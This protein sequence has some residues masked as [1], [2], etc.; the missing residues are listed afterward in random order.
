[1]TKKNSKKEFDLNI[2]VFDFETDRDKIEAFLENRK[3]GFPE[4]VLESV[5]RII[6]EVRN[7][8]DDALYELT[9][10]FDGF[11]LDEN[12]IIISDDELEAAFK[13]ISNELVRSLEVA[14]E[15]IRS[16][17][18]R[19]LQKSVL[20]EDHLGCLLGQIV[21][22]VQRA[23]I[24]VPGGR[25]N[26]PSTALMNIIP[27]Q[28]AGVDEIYVCVP[29]DREGK[30]SQTTLAALYMLKP[31]KV[32]RVG[33]AQAIAALALGTRTIPKVDVIAGPGNIYVAAAKK[34][35]YG[36]VGIDMVAG[37]SEVVVV[38]DETANPAWVSRDL[39]AQA[40][41]D[42]YAS[43]YLITN[44]KKLIRDVLLK[45]KSLVPKSQRSEI[46][47]E[48]LNNNCAFF[49]VS[50]I[51]QGVNLANE[52]SPEHL[53]LETE[54]PLQILP[55]VK[56]CGAVF[57]GG[58]TAESFGDYILGPNH[59]LPT[60]S[61]ARFASPLSAN[62]FTKT[63]SVAYAPERA[64]IELYPYLKEIALSEGLYEH[65]RAAYERFKE[66]RKRQ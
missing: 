25:A 14:S 2:R 36:E 31:T 49:L 43:A 28:V 66:V 29:P 62:T 64:V 20:Y 3:K 5:S 9:L 45:L 59:T 46:I 32:F 16:F 60:Q 48:A 50:S 40:E 39:L 52:I 65:E 37:P 12:T 38:A 63:I 55:L 17:H 1:M 4:E 30:V 18:E 33:G 23:G 8:G 22:P 35:L 42:P 6:E 47:A 24:Y 61:T 34:M 58:T 15:R 54:K 57:L 41:H 7:K 26:Y 44:S 21:R 56:S 11:A 51:E 27:A 13:N 53:E 10:R 19:F